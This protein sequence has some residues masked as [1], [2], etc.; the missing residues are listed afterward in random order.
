MRRHRLLLLGALLS[1]CGDQPSP[2]KERD[3]DAV[4]SAQPATTDRDAAIALAQR[5]ARDAYGA[6]VAVVAASTER[7]ALVAPGETQAHDGWT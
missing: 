2:V 6:R 5:S 4:I 1:G 3:A 7:G